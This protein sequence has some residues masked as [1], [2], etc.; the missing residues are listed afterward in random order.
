M[1]IRLDMRPI[2]PTTPQHLYTM[3]TARSDPCTMTWC[4]NLDFQPESDDSIDN[5]DELGRHSD[6]NLLPSL[7]S[8]EGPKL[9]TI[10]GG[11]QLQFAESLNKVQPAEPHFGSSNMQ[12]GV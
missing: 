1:S 9:S 8:I 11:Q 5:T 4:A 3:T 10:P 7:P 6:L 12:I 2:A